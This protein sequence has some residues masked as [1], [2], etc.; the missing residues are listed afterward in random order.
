MCDRCKM[1]VYVGE[2]ERSLKE[3]VSE[4]MRDVKNQAEKPIMRHFNGHKVY[5]MHYVVL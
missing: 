4:H 5:G 2:T 3:R 1:T